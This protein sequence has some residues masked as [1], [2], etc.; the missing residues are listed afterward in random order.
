MEA[1]VMMNIHSSI[2]NMGY[3]FTVGL[4]SRDNCLSNVYVNQTNKYTT[5][6]AMIK[7]KKNTD[8]TQ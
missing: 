6:L 8:L 5:T 3:M 7:H 4:D 1:K 2:T